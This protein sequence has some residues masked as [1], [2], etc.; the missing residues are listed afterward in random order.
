MNAKHI[1]ICIL[2]L[3]L[4]PFAFAQKSGRYVNSREGLN[5]HAEPNAGAA[6][7]GALKSGEFVAVAVEGEK[8]SID[9]IE[10]RGAKIIINLN[11]LN[12]DDDYNTY[13]W[14]FGG[15]LQEKMPDER[16]RDYQLSQTAQQNRRGL[17]SDRVFPRRLRRIYAGKGMGAS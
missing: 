5:I 15:Y 7:V 9:G 1:I 17:A 10:A 4:S 6:K 13:G 2:A 14:V 16:R 8:A 3:I 11:G 12:L